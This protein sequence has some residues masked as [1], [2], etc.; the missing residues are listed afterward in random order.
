[1]Y[2]MLSTSESQ[3][4]TNLITSRV[5]SSAPPTYGSSSGITSDSS[6]QEELILEQGAGAVQNIPRMQVGTTPIPN[7]VGK[8]IPY[9]GGTSATSSGILIMVLKHIR[10]CAPKFTPRFYGIDGNIH[11]KEC[12][13]R[14]ESTGFCEKGSTSSNSNL[15]SSTT[16]ST[17]GIAKRHGSKGHGEDQGW[18]Q[19]TLAQDKDQGQGASLFS[20]YHLQGSVLSTLRFA[21]TILT[22]ARIRT[23]YVSLASFLTSGSPPQSGPAIAS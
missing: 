5:R 17:I 19:R 22:P 7:R 11:A 14:E 16:N 2:N 6:K 21:C 9:P 4:N 15:Q 1:M 8:W 18:G 23:I 20:Q 12:D 3:G 13:R 10:A